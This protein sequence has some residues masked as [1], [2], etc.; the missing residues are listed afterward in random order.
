M[1]GRSGSNAERGVRVSYS[2]PHNMGARA[3]YELDVDCVSLT[4]ICALQWNYGVLVLVRVLDCDAV[5]GVAMRLLRHNVGAYA[6]C[7]AVRVR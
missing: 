1:I 2:V 3:V 5:R 7:F 4:A 6:V